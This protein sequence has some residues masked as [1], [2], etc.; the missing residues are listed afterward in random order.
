[1]EG[2]NIVIEY[3]YSEGKDSRLPDLAGELVRPKVDVIFAPT[4]TAALAVKNAT[5]EIPIITAT[6]G[7]PVGSGLVVSL[8]RHGGNVTGQ[9]FRATRSAWYSP[10]V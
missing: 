9:I 7:D 2:Q 4:T 1:V 5:S 8:V 6:A 3:R 10:L